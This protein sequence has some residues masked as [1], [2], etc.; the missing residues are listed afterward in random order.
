MNVVA[1]I[2]SEAASLANG[3]PERAPRIFGWAVALLFVAVLIGATAPQV[4]A[5]GCAMCY[6]NAASA[7]AQ[8]R[9]ALRHGILILLLPALSLFAGIL[10]LVCSRD[11]RR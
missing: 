3:F 9:I 4:I 5:Q 11:A 7:G 6:Q 2:A 1:S 10:L 8:G